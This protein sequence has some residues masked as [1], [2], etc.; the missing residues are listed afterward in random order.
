MIYISAALNNPFSAPD[1]FKNLFSRVFFLIKNKTLEF[2]VYRSNAIIG[3][4]FSLSLMRDHAGLSL[5]LDL[6]GC[7]CQL[8]IKDNRHWNYDN[9]DWE[10]G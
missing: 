5:D 3:F 4:T 9:N 1:G 7:G 6:F 2:K 10:H 8:T